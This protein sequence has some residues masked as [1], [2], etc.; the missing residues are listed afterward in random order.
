MKNR[1][2]KA[3]DKITDLSEAINRYVPDGAHISIGGFTINRNPM[4]AVYEMIRRKKRGFHLYAHSNG[5]GVDELI[6]AGCIEK[7][8]IAYAGSGRFASTCV[9]FKKA[10]QNGEIVVEDY[11]N[12]QMTLRFQAGT[13]GVP[14]LPTRSGLGTD[15]VKKW[16]FDESMRKND[17]KIPDKKLDIIDNPFGSWADTSKVVLVPAVCPDVTILHVQKADRQGTLRIEGLPFADVVQAKAAR[18][19]IVTCEELVSSETLR[20]NPDQ[21]Q[22]PFFCV[23]AVVHIP[24]GAYPTAC[25]QYYDYDP[26]YLNSYRN[27][28]R[29]EDSY[30]G[31]LEKFIYGTTDHQAL[32]DLIGKDRIKTIIADPHTGYATGLDRR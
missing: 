31:Y 24:L 17:P 7:L 2:N 13:M 26:V 16:G 30:Q 32:I 22:V 5:Q 18:K 20:E 28:A 4:A 27:W 10:V 8:E 15:I 11:S 6:G 23:D 19:V 21:N 14:F 3:P 12:Y 29:K 25:Y 1:M 9:R